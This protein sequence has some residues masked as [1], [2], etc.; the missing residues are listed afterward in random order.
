MKLNRTGLFLQVRLNSIRMPGKAL[1]DLS[2]KPLITHVMN[3]L[4]VVP[5]DVRAIVTSEESAS[6][7]TPIAIAAGWEVFVG[8]SQNVLKRYVDAALYYDIDT[9]IRAT[10]DN[11][12]SSSEIAI[13]TIGLFHKTNADLA[14]L[15]P[16]PYGSGVEVVKR[17]ALEKALFSTKIPYDLEHVTPFIYKNPGMF[18]IVTERYH[19][20]E[21]ARSDV[22]IT[23]DT[24]EDYE[25]VNYFIKKINEKKMNL[26]IHS[27]VNIW[28][29]LKF[30]KFKSILFVT[31]VGVNLGLGHLKRCFSLAE[32]LKDQYHIYFTFKDD[33]DDALS[34]VKAKKYN[35]LNFTDIDKYVSDNGQFDRVIVDL[36]DTD[37]SEMKKYL[38]Y[39]PVISIDDM[40]EGGQYAFVNVRTLPSINK[41][42]YIFN[43]DGLEYLFIPE[44]TNKKHKI[45]GLKKIVVTFG[46]S[47]PSLLTNKLL[48]RLTGN[49]YDIT[50]IS[51]PFFKERVEN[52]D[53]CKIIY[54]P[55]TVSTYID[56]AD[57]VITS[58]GMTLMESL[59]KQIPVMLM[60]PT[61]YHD[62]L[63]EAF[64]YPYYIKKDDIDSNEKFEVVFGECINKMVSDGC[65]SNGSQKLN[66]IY[67]LNFGAKFND[68]VRIIKE[69]TPSVNLCTSC[70]S[71][72]TEIVGRNPLWNMYRCPS[73][74]L[75]YLEYICENKIDYD[76]DYFFK[77]Y[78]EHYGKTYEEDRMNIRKFSERR[79]KMIKKYVKSGDLL[80]F[81]SGLGFFAEY[82]KE[83]GFKT[84][85]YDVS[86]YAVEYIKNKLGMEALN[87]DQSYLEKSDDIYDVIASF[88]VI[89]HIREFE[90]LIFMFA[91]HL[92]KGG[93]LALSTPNGTGVSVRRKFKQYIKHHPSDHYFIFNPSMLKSVLIKNGFKN[94]KIRITGIHPIR[95]VS[96][97]KNLKNKLF[98]KIIYLY[99]KI[100]KLG[101]TFEI[102]AQKS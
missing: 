76:N 20:D 4:M 73:C 1:L 48:R 39:G 53:D 67:D 22:R 7:L 89:E 14:H 98:Y 63:T 38:F 40:G 3:R 16:V 64:S 23:V 18:K 30:D 56:D 77:E 71:N 21:A 25:R 13:Q 72:K 11:P 19:N 60:N 28:D 51:G 41:K 80:D 93:V 96:S 47:D 84:M 68:L 58:F 44:N 8:H 74:G 94:I 49:G 42:D 101:D 31:G 32:A 2:G 61:Y 79:L 78:K 91:N 85:C 90:K 5:A 83:N 35:F 33:N 54:S 87:A 24:R 46:G 34:M 66:K 102:Y 15:E 62:A 55:D 50:V 6:I 12:L 45:D 10:G 27:V 70:C 65:F 97:K 99:A 17:S 100:F 9:V 75:Y 81:G 36:R 69:S 52:Y 92:K 57:L 43:L 26:T 82:A 29:E 95:V 59:K 88:Y 37:K 86:D